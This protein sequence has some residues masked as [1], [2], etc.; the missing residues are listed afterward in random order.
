MEM[1]AIHERSAALL[2]AIWRGVPNSYKSRYRRTIWQ[3]FEDQIRSAA[4]TNS[5]GKFVNNICLALGVEI[6]GKDVETVNDVL[7]GGEDRALLKLLRDET[8]LLV[9]MVRVE[10]QARSE[11]W[12]AAEAVRQAERAE[13][14]DAL[15]DPLFGLPRAEFE[16]AKGEAA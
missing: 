10:N 9:L 2:T 4:Y 8:T 3:Q 1:D 7:R 11:E 12:K 6:L 14:E 13:E 15:N 16:E 5:L